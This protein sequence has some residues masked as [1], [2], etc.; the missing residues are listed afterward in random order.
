[1]IKGSIICYKKT[2]LSSFFYLPA[3]DA[4]AA[5]INVIP[6]GN[7]EKEFWTKGDCI[8]TTPSEELDAALNFIIFI[9]RSRGRWIQNNKKMYKK[10]KHTHNSPAVP[11]YCINVAITIMRK[12]I[13]LFNVTLNF[14]AT[15]SHW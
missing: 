6:L 8:P 2:F 5:I 12:N 4:T 10:K 3:R 11:T 9:H 14:Q 15:E 13:Y 7:L 1:M